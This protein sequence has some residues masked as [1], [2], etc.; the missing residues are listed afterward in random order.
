MTSAVAI[1]RL[2][3]GTDEWLAARRRRIG[4]SEI[5]AVLGISPYESRFSLWHRK[6]GDVDPVEV[7]EPMLWGTLLEP[8]VAARFDTL[9]P[10]WFVRTTPAFV[11]PERDYQTAAPDRLLFATRR[12]RRPRAIYEGKTARMAD[13][14]GEPGTDEVPPHYRAQCLW[15]L[16]CLGLDECHVAVLIGGSEYREYLVRHDQAEAE[17]MRKAAAEFVASLDTGP[18]PSIDEHAATYQAV[19]ELHPDIDGSAIEV[20]AELADGYT[21]ACAGEKAAKD[22]KRQAAAR[23]AD[24]MGLA[25]EAWCD[26]RKVALRIP[27]RDGNPPHLSP[28]KTSRKDAAA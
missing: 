17:L 5:A 13:E 24:F 14:W 9:H 4:G 28:A 19:K 20:P 12:A 25:R 10:E 27:G 26:G 15:Y 22:T 1:G 3:P 6:R 18:R 11:H 23:L 8:T 2:E 7:T 21:E 16:D